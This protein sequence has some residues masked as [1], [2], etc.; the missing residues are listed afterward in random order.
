[1]RAAGERL[2]VKWLG[3][4]VRVPHAK[5]RWTTFGDQLLVATE[6]SIATLA[7][8]AGNPIIS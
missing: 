1:M 4:A 7:A 2:S 6:I 5:P 8:L 3:F